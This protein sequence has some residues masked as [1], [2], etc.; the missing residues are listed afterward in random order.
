MPTTQFCDFIYDSLWGRVE[1]QNKNFKTTFNKL[2][3]HAHDHIQSITILP[4][5]SFR[6]R[7]LKGSINSIRDDNQNEN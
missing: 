1:K 2:I 6:R 3:M 5:A 7:A 4:I